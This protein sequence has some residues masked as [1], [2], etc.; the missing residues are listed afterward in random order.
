MGLLKGLRQ[1][2]KRTFDARQK[3]AVLEFLRK[4]LPTMTLD[5]I[6]HLLVNPLGRGLGSLKIGDLLSVPDAA[7]TKGAA[8]P[9]AAPKRKRPKAA[10]KPTA[11]PAKNKR[12]KAPKSTKPKATPK[13]AA[14]PKPPA[15]ATLTEIPKPAAA[16]KPPPVAEPPQAPTPS[17]TTAGYR[18]AVLAVIRAANGWIGA[19]EIRPRVEG[20]TMQFRLAINQ[21]I[22]AGVIARKGDR[23]T[24]R[25]KYI[26]ADKA[27]QAPKT[28]RTR[29][30][31]SSA[32]ATVGD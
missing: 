14:A 7:Q 3:E 1:H 22:K 31:D 24:T 29:A 12:K 25:Y 16:P 28:K 19:T 30:P 26:G 27:S 15:T 6:R 17:T 21:H 32:D 10:K 9:K 2:L 23:S 20:T 11:K 5:D 18:A 13:P 8:K 4:Q